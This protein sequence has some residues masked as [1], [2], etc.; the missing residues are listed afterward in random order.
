M[1]DFDS[2]LIGQ[3]IKSDGKE[4]MV[5]KPLKADLYLVCDPLA[6]LPAPV[7]LVK[8]DKEDV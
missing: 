5:L 1:F 6:P 8:K 2:M 3:I 4:W 7:F